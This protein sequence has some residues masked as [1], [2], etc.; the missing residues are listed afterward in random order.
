[1][2][3]EAAGSRRQTAILP[4]RATTAGE[5]LDSAVALLRQRALPLLIMAAVLAAGEQ[6]LLSRLRAAVPLYPPFY[7]PDEWVLGEWWRIT[8]TGLAIE[9]GIITLLGAFAGAAAGP[10]LLGVTVRHRELFRRVR[11]GRALLIAVL[12]GALAWPAAYFGGVGLIALFALTGL[13]TPVLAMDRVGNPVLAVLRAVRLAGRGGM[14]VGR[15]RIVGYLTWLG[16]RVGLGFGWIMVARLLTV[17]V[18]GAAWLAWAIPAAWG[19][20][21]T[22]AYAALACLDAVLLVEVR[23]RTEG[24]D[25]ALNR[26][27]AHGEDEAATL[28][29]AR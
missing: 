7:Q 22:A 5:S 23:I 16:I 24:L 29:A 4:L 20:A 17:N 12:L 9:V 21:N 28:V 6:V 3:G 10:A 2:R 27:R 13:V 25:I 8:A 15:I 11:L 18:D 14:R 1:M 19:L 26:S